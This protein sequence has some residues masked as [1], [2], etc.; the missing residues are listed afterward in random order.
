MAARALTGAGWAGT[1]MTGRKLLADRFDAKLLSRA[2]GG[3]AA[4]IGI[5]G[6]LSFACADLVADLAGWK[7]A[8]FG[9]STTAALA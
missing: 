2:T 8:F 4:S 6:A 3:H 1:Y 9:V 7:A 5:S